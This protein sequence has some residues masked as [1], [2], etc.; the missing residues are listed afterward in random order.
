[1]PSV[2][3]LLLSWS[4]TMFEYLMPSWWMRSHAN[5]LAV[6][7]PAACVGVQRDF[8]APWAFPGVSRNPVPARKDDAGHYHYH[9]YG[10]PQIALWFEATA[11]L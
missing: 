5:T 11:A 6:S 9:A 8:T 10:V 7:H 3:Y 1:M 2:Y 4:G